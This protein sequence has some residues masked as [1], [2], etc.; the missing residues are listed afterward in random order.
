MWEC[1]VVTA[2]AIEQAELLGPLAQFGTAGLI[3]WM[4]ITERRSSAEADRRL[5]AS[6]ERILE[7]RQQIDEFVA[8]ISGNTRA[9][10]ALE[11]S[12]RELSGAIERAAQRTRDD[13]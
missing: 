13:L 2:G 10:V 9:M 3:A 4:W 6:H 8:V 5:A 7:Q 11:G 1:A 12:Q